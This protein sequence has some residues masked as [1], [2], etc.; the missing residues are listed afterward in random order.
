[1][2]KWI[3]FSWIRVAADPEARRPDSRAAMLIGARTRVNISRV[4]DRL[5][6]WGVSTRANAR[7]T[8]ER[9]HA[10]G[11]SDP[12]YSDEQSPIAS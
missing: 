12:G 8:L 10:A 7:A 11:V 2:G 1:M 3:S 6:R 9:S 5:S 4:T